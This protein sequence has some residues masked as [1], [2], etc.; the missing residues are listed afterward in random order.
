MR[1]VCRVIFGRLL[2][3]V[4]AGA[5]GA[6]LAVE[7]PPPAA[8]ALRLEPAQTEVYVGQALRIDLTWDCGLAARTL[9]DLRLNPAFFENPDIEVVIPRNTSATE[10]QVGLPIGGRRVIATRELWAEAPE[11]LGTIR[12]PIYLRF[13][14]PGSYE[15]DGARLDVAVVANARDPFGRYAAYFNNSFFEAVGSADR[16][17][18]RTTEAAPQRIE[19]RARPVDTEGR[20]SGWFEPVEMEWTLGQAAMEVGDL[21][22]IELKLSGEAPHGMWTPPVLAEQSALNAHF[23]LDENWTREWH[24]R[25]TIFRSRMRILSTRVAAFPELHFRVFDP[26]AGQYRLRRTEAIP[27]QVAPSEG[28]TFIPLKSFS[29]RAVALTNHPGGIWHNLKARPMNE[30][31]STL[32]QTVVGLFWPLLIAAPVA[33]AVLCPILRERRR[34][35]EDTRYR[36]CAEAY[37]AFRKLPEHTPAKWSAFLHLMAVHFDADGRAWTRRDSEAALRAIGATDAEV[38][39]LLAMHNAADRAD[40]G[41][42]PV[43]VSWRSLNPVAKRLRVLAVRSVWVLGLLLWSAPLEMRADTW[44]EAEELFT[45]A[46]AGALEASGAVIDY[47]DAALKY[48]ATARE[49]IRPGQAFYNAGNAWFMAGEIGRAI[50][51][52]RKAEAFRPFDVKLL[53]NLAV[54][55]ALVLSEVPD[56]RPL[57]Q[58][59]PRAQVKL[60]LLCANFAFWI[61]L[62]LVVRYRN[63]AVRIA[64]AV[65]TLALFLA[66]ALLLLQVATQRVSGV[67]IVNSVTAKK[68]PGY[69]YADAFNE[70][71]HSGLEFQ[72][73]EQR[74]EWGRI[75]LTDGRQCWIPLRCVQL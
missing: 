33:F 44:N 61:T 7:T 48:E 49:G 70:S 32:L 72:L 30:T 31:L 55:R 4:A 25:G 23:L 68:G 9:K 50:A 54:A 18:R 45:R 37:A 39:A 17:E 65:A 56:E 63:R 10:A 57:W 6:A 41:A 5:A 3:A 43:N 42:R 36:R 1:A 75:E 74:D 2:W 46:Q 13:S 15:L 22:E 47:A 69:G 12:L 58:R 11:A 14:Q 67:V 29:G 73:I 28:R 59:L 62:M 71:L 19:V 51:A 64:V 20:F 24:A 27:L 60:A 26:E 53:E 38:E 66:V 16:Y 40:F 8:L 34:R 21:I 35:A 52:Y